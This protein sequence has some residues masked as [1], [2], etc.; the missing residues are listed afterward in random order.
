M[1]YSDLEYMVNND[2]MFLGFD[3]GDVNDV[4]MYWEI[5]LGD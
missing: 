4:N 2:M 1:Y 3:P 5:M